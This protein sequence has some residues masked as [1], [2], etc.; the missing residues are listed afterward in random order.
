VSIDG[1]VPLVAEPEVT[2]AFD[3]EAGIPV[4]ALLGKIGVIHRRLP[5]I[6]AL[7]VFGVGDSTGLV[8]SRYQ[9][10]QLSSMNQRFKSLLCCIPPATDGG[11]APPERRCHIP[12]ADYPQQLTVNM[13]S[14]NQLLDIGDKHAHLSLSGS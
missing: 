13:F 3:T 4:R 2:L 14:T 1:D 5:G 7:V 9:R 6:V 10:R 8:L 12:P 11:I